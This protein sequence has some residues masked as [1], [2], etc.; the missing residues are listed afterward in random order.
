MLCSSVLGELP[1]T[2]TDSPAVATGVVVV[3]SSHVIFNSP[4]GSPATEG[5]DE[6]GMTPPSPPAPPLLRDFTVD[7]DLMFQ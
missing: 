5:A 1:F 4:G 2:S 3:E 6:V 7:L